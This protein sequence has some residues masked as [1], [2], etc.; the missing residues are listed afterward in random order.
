MVD[1]SKWERFAADLSSDEEGTGTAPRVTTFNEKGRSITIGP[2]GATVVSNHPLE[3]SSISQ[4][5]AGKEISCESEFQLDSRNGG[6][7]G[8]F[9][10]SQ[11]RYDVCIRKELAP[12]VK[13]GDI[14]IHFDHIESRLIIKNKSTK[15]ALIEG[16]TRY[17]FEVNDDDI[18]PVNWEIVSIPDPK[19]DTLAHRV[20]EITL[21]KVSPIPGAVIWWK[22]VFVDDPEIDV[23]KI[24][25]R[26]I[27]STSAASASAWEEA[28]KMFREKIAAE[29]RQPIQIDLDDDSE[30]ENADETAE[31]DAR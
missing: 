3:R 19:V 17:K 20:L 8:T 28:H 24:A 11:D 6:V 23:T 12:E 25:D 14:L 9:T 18:C 15:E 21:R 10:W 22:H 30:D 29:H 1:Y 31:D 13:A 27:S 26:V 5:K 7:T 2:T 16:T 4:P